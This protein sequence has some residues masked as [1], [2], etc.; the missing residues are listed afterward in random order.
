M[1]KSKKNL[2]VYAGLAGAAYL[3]YKAYNMPQVKT[4]PVYQPVTSPPVYDRLY[5]DAHLT[6]VLNEHA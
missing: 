5:Q 3:V 1:A 2:I 4:R 6:E